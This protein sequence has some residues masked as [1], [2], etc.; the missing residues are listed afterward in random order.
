MAITTQTEQEAM[1]E[2][3]AFNNTSLLSAVE[4]EL[5]G[6][7]GMYLQLMH[8]RKGK[9]ADMEDWGSD[10][11][12]FGPIDFVHIT[13]NTSINV[14][15]SVL[16]DGGVVDNRQTGPMTDAPEPLRFDEDML[17]YDGVYY[18]DWEIFTH[19]GN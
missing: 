16:C 2:Q 6:A 9:D 12:C 7:P 1:H 15:V 13:Y 3:S 17:F 8:G 19:T 4:C 11:P 5:P 14:G 10:G 18:G